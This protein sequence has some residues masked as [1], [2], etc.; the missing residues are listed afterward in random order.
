MPVQCYDGSCTCSGIATPGPT[1]AQALEKVVCAL[2][3]LLNS[4]AKNMIWLLLQHQI[5]QNLWLY[6]HSYSVVYKCPGISTILDMP[7]C[8]WPAYSEV[9]R[10]APYTPTLDSPTFDNRTNKHV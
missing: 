7:L 9:G 2:V 5:T 3:K 4:W 6:S 8:T 1:G 10:C